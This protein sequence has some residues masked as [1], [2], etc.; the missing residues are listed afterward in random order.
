MA[1]SQQKI[2]AITNSLSPVRLGTYLNATGFGHKATVLD[3]YVWNAL[4]SGALFSSLHICEVV[5]RNAISHALELKYGANW[6]W[7]SGFERTLPKWSKADLQKARN[8]ITVGST[9]KVIAELKFAF[10]CKLFTAGQDQHIWNVHLHMVFPFVPLP[11]TVAAARK[12]LYDDMESLRIF[13]NRIAHHEPIFSYPLNDCQTRIARLIKLR[14]GDTEQ[15]LT[16]WETVSAALAM[17]P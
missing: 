16:Q 15:W 12:K 10:W 1:L 3:I 11:L 9:G 5:M 4:V 14:C 2:A 17:R 13:R 7:D 8:G 6:P